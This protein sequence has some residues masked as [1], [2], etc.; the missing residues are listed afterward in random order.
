MIKKKV[1]NINIGSLNSSLNS[2]NQTEDKQANSESKLK[3][4]E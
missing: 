2:I 4:T 3:Q 1:N